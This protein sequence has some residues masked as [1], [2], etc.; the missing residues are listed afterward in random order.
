MPFAHGNYGHLVC[1]TEIESVS[2]GNEQVWTLTLTPEEVTEGIGSDVQYQTNGK[3]YT[4]DDFAKMRAGRLLLNDPPP[5]A[6]QRGYDEGAMLENFISG[7]DGTVPI[8]HC[9]VKEMVGRYR[10]Q[11]R[12]ALQSARLTSVYYLLAGRV[13]EAIQELTLGPIGAGKVHVRF[14][15]K[16]RQRYANEPAATIQIEGDCLLE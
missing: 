7:T 6:K 4:P 14:R 16:R 9:V 15:G 10:N 3:T 13:A 8:R 1:V 12:L 11:P 5:P 2:E